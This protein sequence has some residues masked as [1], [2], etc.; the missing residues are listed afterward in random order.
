VLLLPNIAFLNP[1]TDEDTTMKKFG[2]ACVALTLVGSM[3]GSASA[4]DRALSVPASTLSSMGL[5]GVHPMSDTA[6]LAV[7]GMG[8]PGSSAGVWG[9]SIAVKGDNNSTNG[10]GASASH[11]HGSSTANGSNFS[12]AGT[13]YGS[14]SNLTTHVNI[15]GGNSSA[16]AK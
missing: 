4:A 3:I 12:F 14:L 6:G 10:Y 11:S 1:G 2:I 13:A 8:A 5:A 15:A 7:R 9:N 16:F